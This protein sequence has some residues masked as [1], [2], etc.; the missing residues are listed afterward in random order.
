M[1]SKKT[2]RELTHRFREIREQRSYASREGTFARNNK[3]AA[4]HV[5]ARGNEKFVG[6]NCMFI[7]AEESRDWRYKVVSKIDEGWAKLWIIDRRCMLLALIRKL[8][9]EHS[10]SSGWRVIHPRELRLSVLTSEA[11]I[12]LWRDFRN[13]TVLYAD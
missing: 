13:C 4:L 3:I 8:V 9:M 2:A 1:G 7:C 10:E 12:G 11:G 6:F 5:C